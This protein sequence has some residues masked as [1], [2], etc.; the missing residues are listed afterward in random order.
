MEEADAAHRSRKKRAL[1]KGRKWGGKI[2]K[3][4][5]RYA[6]RISWSAAK[7][8]HHHHRLGRSHIT[9]CRLQT[10]GPPPPYHRHFLFPLSLETIFSPRTHTGFPRISVVNFS[11][12]PLRRWRRGLRENVMRPRSYSACLIAQHSNPRHQKWET[13]RL[14]T[15]ITS[16][17]LHDHHK[18]L[19]T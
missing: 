2:V 3:I 11:F 10:K 7:V 15:E 17:T 16:L 13:R 8:Q 1:K 5:K 6:S 12:S 19:P 14:N 9:V 18:H 4:G